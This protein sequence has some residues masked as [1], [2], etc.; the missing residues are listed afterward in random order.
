MFG[1][2]DPRCDEILR[3]ADLATS[4][5]LVDGQ[6][7]RWREL[8]TQ[9]LGSIEAAGGRRRQDL[10]GPA[11]LEVDILAPD[12]MASLATSTV[13]GGGIS[14]RIA[15]VIP[16]GTPIDLSIKVPQRRVP[17]LVTAQVVW[18]R[19]GE[20]G[21]AFVGLPENDRELLEGVAVKALLE[22]QVASIAQ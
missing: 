8:V 9:L 11:E 15:E 3:L 17:L 22:G 18:S 20:L 13:S 21:A 5:R 19:P 7:P 14:M 4:D 16:I 6:R 12:E 1:P 10:R 2:G